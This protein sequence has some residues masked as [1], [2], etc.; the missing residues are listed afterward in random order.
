MDDQGGPKEGG[1][2]DKKIVHVYPLVKVSFVLVVGFVGSFGK[3]FHVH[4]SFNSFEVVQIIARV[5]NGETKEIKR[6]WVACEN[7]ISDQISR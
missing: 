5:T 2:G 6:W 4:Y 7:I 3:L 1:E